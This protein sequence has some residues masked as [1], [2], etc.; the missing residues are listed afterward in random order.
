MAVAADLAGAVHWLTVTSAAL[1]WLLLRSATAI[2][3]PF[4]VL[5]A[6]IG[7]IVILVAI[8]IHSL[9]VLARHV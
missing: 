7:E 4:D 3:C 9:Q 2:L 8:R 1:D 6:L 5:T